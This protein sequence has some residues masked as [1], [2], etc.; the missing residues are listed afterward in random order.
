MLISDIHTTFF[1]FWVL[2]VSRRWTD[3]KW[4]RN[5]GLPRTGDREAVAG[6]VQAVLVAAAA[7][8]T[9]DEGAE[10]DNPEEPARVLTCFRG[11]RRGGG[12][13]GER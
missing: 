3:R 10:A 11:G 1:F 12:D 4:V 9:A 5:L 8:V 6:P 2:T 13:D 7:T